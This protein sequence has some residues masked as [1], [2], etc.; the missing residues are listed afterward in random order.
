[1]EN[2][3][4][5][6]K[7]VRDFMEQL[8]GRDVIHE[9]NDSPY[10]YIHLEA[11]VKVKNDMYYDLARDVMKN[12]EGAWKFVNDAVEEMLDI[13][14]LGADCDEEKYDEL[15]EQARLNTIVDIIDTLTDI[16]YEELT[17]EE[18]YTYYD[19]SRVYHSRRKALYDGLYHEFEVLQDYD[20]TLEEV[21]DIMC[22]ELN[23]WDRL[24]WKPV[25]D[26]DIMREIAEEH[27]LADILRWAIQNNYNPYADYFAVSDF[28]TINKEELKDIYVEELDDVVDIL[29]R[30]GYR[31]DLYEGL[32]HI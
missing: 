22:G 17:E 9:G 10:D 27:S 15:Y 1:M 29:I 20:I 5:E 21:R 8:K 32:V 14:G 4:K 24:Y 25:G 31:Y 18:Y 19:E 12:E 6:C 16:V 23:Q 11:Q 2:F 7:T 13:E 26:E 28:T 30:T 3:L